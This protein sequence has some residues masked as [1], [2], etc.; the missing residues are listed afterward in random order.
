MRRH[1]FGSNLPYGYN[2][3]ISEDHANQL[4][5]VLSKF[6]KLQKMR[7][8]IYARYKK[9]LS[10]YNI[11]EKKDGTEPS[12][13]KLVLLTDRRNELK[14]YLEKYGIETKIHYKNTLDEK[15]IVHYP[16]AKRLCRQALS[17]PIYP[18]LKN[19]EIDYICEKI[20]EFQNV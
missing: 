5:F 13:H 16:N 19:N 3:L 1:G 17:L 12:Y 2:S 4:L 7:G 6:D 18:F 9:N 14:D 10:N 11:I 15:N 20:Q 8:K